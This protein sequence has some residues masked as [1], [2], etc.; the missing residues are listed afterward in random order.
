MVLTTQGGC[1]LGWRTQVETRGKSTLKQLW[2][3]LSKWH[4][5][6]RGEGFV[7]MGV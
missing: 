1:K 4:Q 6:V 3:Q 7:S 2:L 5:V